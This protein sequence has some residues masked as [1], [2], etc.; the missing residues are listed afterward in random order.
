MTRASL[1]K[2]SAL[3]S[4]LLLGYAS[5]AHAD[6]VSVG[7]S[8]TGVGPLS[9]QGDTLSLSGQSGTLT[10]DTALIATQN[11]NSAAFFT[12]NSGFFSGSQTLNL[13]YDLTLGGV[14]QALTQT[15]TWTITPSQDT[16][17]ALAASSPVQF[18]TPLGTWDVTLGAYS[19]TSS[20]I[21]LTQIGSAPA[22]FAPVPE[23]SSVALLVAGV[24][25]L[26]GLAL[27]KKAIT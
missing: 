2:I 22:A 10:L 4:L 27:Q 17:Y 21:N 8:T 18:V 7:Y 15:G 19:F 12:G 3:C 6:T 26:L 20:S 9:F 11:I 13:A 24:A 25:V 14:T 16:F 5:Q 1:V 23:P